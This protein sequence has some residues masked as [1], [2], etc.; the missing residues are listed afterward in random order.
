MLQRLNGPLLILIA[1]LLWGTDSLYRF[2]TS[3]SV[4]ATFIVLIE[5]I[6]GFAVLLPWVWFK[7][8]NELFKL[9]W[10]GWLSSFIV[11]AG[12]GA[13]ATVL[14]TASFKYLNPSV[15]IL[16]QKLQPVFVV[17][18]AFL[19]LGERPPAKFYL[20]ALLALGAGFVLSFPDLDVTFLAD[21]NNLHARGMIYALVAAMIWAVSTVAGRSLLMRTSPTV[22]TF[23]R[24]G[25]GLGT[26]VTIM[27]AA[28]ISADMASISS[29]P[30]IM[31]LLY[32]SFVTG[33][34]PSSSIMPVWPKPRPT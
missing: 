33:L 4:D 31:A 26:L 18:L 2:P 23:W 28:N 20:W 29:Q 14:F 13:V 25:F 27:F 34:I 22:A 21:P 19:F 12:G 7:H 8:R 17:I 15:T 24:Y 6:A 32:L 16:L 30:M 10:K 11:G 5:H 1:A 3:S 9:G